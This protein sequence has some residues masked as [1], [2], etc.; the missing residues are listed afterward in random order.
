MPKVTYTFDLP[1]EAETLD[2]FMRGPDYLR[3]FRAV[4]LKVRSKPKYESDSLSGDE[5]KAYNQ[6]REWICDACQ[7]EGV[8][9]PW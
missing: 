2:E 7:E 8:E 1:E 3:A 6:V 4:W 9:V 5:L